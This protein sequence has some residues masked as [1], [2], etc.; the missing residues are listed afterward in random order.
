MSNDDDVTKNIDKVEHL[1]N[2]AK[3][4]KKI[5][6]ERASDRERRERQIEIEIEN[7]QR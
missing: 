5:S 6:D 2:F 4:L 1:S 7:D 3:I